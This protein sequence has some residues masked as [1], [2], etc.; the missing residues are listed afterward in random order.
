MENQIAESKQRVREFLLT[1][2]ARVE[3]LATPEADKLNEQLLALLT[4]LN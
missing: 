4:L 2:S 3:D 1:E